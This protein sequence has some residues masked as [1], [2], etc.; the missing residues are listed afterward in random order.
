MQNKYWNILGFNNN[1]K[2][3]LINKQFKEDQ[4]IKGILEQNESYVY[5]NYYD[6]KGRE[7][8]ISRYI[9]IQKMQAFKEMD[10]N[11][12]GILTKEEI[13][14]TYKKYMDDETALQEVQNIMGLVDMDGSGTIDY[15][16]FIIASMDR[17]KA[18]QMQKLKEAF[19]IF[20]KDR[21]G[22][23]SELE[24]KEVLGPSLTVIDEKY[25][26]DKIKEIDRNGNGQINFEEF[27]E[28][29]MKIKQ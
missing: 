14:E 16:E 7:K 8:L 1:I 9:I 22:F 26:L 11:G 19:Q 23:I 15:T 29:M 24:I 17:K 5:W 27:C 20:D 4:R 28:M 10:Q 2:K 12:D 6:F 18:V 25:W 3:R 21:N 13:L